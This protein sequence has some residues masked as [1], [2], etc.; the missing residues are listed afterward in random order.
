M[1]NYI[2][3]RLLLVPVLLFGVSILI[4]GMLQFL[5]PDERASLYVRQDFKSENQLN[6]V[7]KK[8]CL[9]C[10]IHLQYTRWLL[11]TIRL[12]ERRTSRRHSLWELWLV[13]NKFPACCRIDQ[14]SLSQ[15]G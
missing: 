11:G 4:F 6:A 5:G 3:R 1:T 9:D 7:I 15:Y 13:E 2:I 14:T 8:Y 10:P 12:C